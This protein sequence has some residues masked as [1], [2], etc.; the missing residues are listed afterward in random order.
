[1]VSAASL[2]GFRARV[3]AV[4]RLWARTPG[5]IQGERALFALQG[6]FPRYDAESTLLKVIAVHSL[7]SSR[8]FPVARWAEHVTQTLIGL[9]PLD[10]GRELVDAL[11]ALPGVKP[12]EHR[13]A[14]T[15]A[16]RFAHYFIDA[17]RFPVLDAWSEAELARLAPPPN[18]DECAYV[19]FATR[20]A[21]LAA[22][23]GMPRARQLGHFLWLAGQYRVWSRNRRTSIQSVARA[24]F[25]SEARELSELIAFDDPRDA[26]VA[27]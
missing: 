6:C 14:L 23:T 12:A 5:L 8:T 19:E 9:D 2:V 7:D 13:R 20:H 22:Q 16:S 27:A 3:A 1:M 11:A 4:E 15:F 25:E 26:N 10:V 17:D 24:L 18:D 21:R